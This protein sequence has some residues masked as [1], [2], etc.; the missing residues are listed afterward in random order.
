MAIGGG[1]VLATGSHDGTA[2]LWDCESGCE[3]ARLEG[4]KYGAFTV[5]FSPDGKLLAVAGHLRGC[6]ANVRLVA[7]QTDHSTLYRFVRGLAHDRSGLE[8]YR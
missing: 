3:L 6:G 2:R 8:N 7:E 5:A 4:H 1:R